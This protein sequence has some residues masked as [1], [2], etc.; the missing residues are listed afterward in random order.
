MSGVVD[1]TIVSSVVDAEKKILCCSQVLFSRA[2]YLIDGR[3]WVCC[4]LIGIWFWRC[5]RLGLLIHHC[6]MLLLMQHANW[7]VMQITNI[8]KNRICSGLELSWLIKCRRIARTEHW[9][10][11][12]SYWIW[13][14][15]WAFMIMRPPIPFWRSR[16]GTLLWGHRCCMIML[17]P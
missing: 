2:Q 11:G 12:T 4:D 6:L 1:S 8:F 16:C 14:L 13:P 10:T 3:L 7:L 17:L 5:C 15:R 9:R